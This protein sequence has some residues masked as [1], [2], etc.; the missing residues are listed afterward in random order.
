[1]GQGNIQNYQHY[2]NTKCHT[3]LIKILLLHFVF[4]YWGKYKMSVGPHFDSFVT[5]RYDNS[6]K[7]NFYCFVT[8]KML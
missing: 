2:K 4:Y 6:I 1:M 7:I 5:L 3:F 8:P